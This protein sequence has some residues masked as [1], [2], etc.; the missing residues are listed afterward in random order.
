MI[1]LAI[2]VVEPDILLKKY[3]PLP[4]SHKN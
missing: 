4:I 2:I 1:V 3:S